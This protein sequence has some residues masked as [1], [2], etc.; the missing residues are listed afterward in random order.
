MNMDIDLALDNDP[1]KNELSK[2][3][4]LK[5]ISLERLISEILEEYVKKE[6]VFKRM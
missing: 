5:G 4:E 3:A 1:L 2:K 6:G